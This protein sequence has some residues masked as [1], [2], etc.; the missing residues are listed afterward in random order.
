MEF[1]RDIYKRLLDW[2]RERSGK[3]LEL[4]GA[5]QVGKTYILKKFAKENFAHM[6]YINMAE[7]SG[8][9]FLQSL[10]EASTWVPGTDREEKPVHYALSLFDKNFRDD[11]ENIIIIDEVQESS[12]VYNLIRT[13]ARE[14]ECY[15]IV[16]GSY[17]GRLLAKDFF[18]PAGDLDSMT[19]ETLTFAEFAGVFGHREL[20]DTIDLYGGG[21]APDYEV[22]R[23]CYKIYQRIGGYPSVVSTYLTHK[24]FDR[25]NEEIW[26]LMSIFI[27]ESKRYFDTVMD[28]N[29][30]AKL[31]HGIAITQIREKQG[32]KGLVED[33]S[34]IVYKQESGRFTK[35]M[36]NHA[37]NWLE[38]SHIIGY[39][40][41]SVDCDYLDVKDNARFYFLDVGIAH[42]FL[43]QA[44]S[45]EAVIKGIVAENFV[46]VS[47]LRRVRKDI[48]GNM[49]WFGSYQKINGELDFY[50]RS[51][52]DQRDYGIEVKS[53]SGE[54]RTARALLADKKIDYLYYLKGASNGGIAEDGI[55]RTVP[56]YLVDRIS[57]ALGN[58][59]V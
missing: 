50:V 36:I 1:T 45:E 51:L 35:K 22:L 2:K 54:G 31:F 11:I 52:A 53:E 59:R 19:M 10:E 14:F 23:E 40:G 27:N 28:T 21:D 48:A 42:Y 6:V 44:G 29:V 47:L 26:R 32:V 30:F 56:L 15:V 49:P 37:I 41:K 17:L 39:A 9:Q 38:A 25:C 43:K 13:L 16:T 34:K 33:L 18:L 4:S 57:F 24:D 5:R 20:Y 3:V 46:Y 55:V 58:N 7:I 8:E 12:K